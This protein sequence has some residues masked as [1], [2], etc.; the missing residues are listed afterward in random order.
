MNTETDNQEGITADESFNPSNMFDSE[1]FINAQEESEELDLKEFDG[2]QVQE[3]IAENSQEN[4]QSNESNSDETNND[5][6]FN[7]DSKTETKEFDLERFNENF[8]TKFTKQEELKEFLQDKEQ[9]TAEDTNKELY[10]TSEN[11][12]KLLE[13]T[14][15]L[16][17]EDLMRKQYESIATQ[18]G[19]DINDNFVMA[20]INEKI[21]ELKDKGTLG[22][23]ARD[24]RRSLDDIIDKAKN[25]IKSID[26]KKQKFEQEQQEN[27]KK[28]L[29]KEFAK[30]YGSEKFYGVDLNKETVE[31]AYRDAVSGKTIEELSGNKQNLA[32]FALFSY[33]KEEIFKKATGKTYSDG[34]KSVLSEFE[35][36]KADL[37][38]AQK[39]G[40]SATG[41][42]TQRGLIDSV[43]YTKPTKEKV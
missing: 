35:T 31:K 36:K 7:N 22:L 28:E 9:K 12:I 5:L 8:G 41:A 40:T 6:D 29:Q 38:M 43:L 10:E 34:I 1:S 26:D 24:L 37:A 25:N 18:N 3:N 2:V 23:E 13:P 4:N 21:E 16:P 32:E 33:F 19:Q 20:D 39:R 42:D 30:I 17:D 27:S 11:Q 14:V 15:N